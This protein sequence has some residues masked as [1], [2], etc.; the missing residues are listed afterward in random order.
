MYRQEAH[1]FAELDVHF[2]SYPALLDLAKSLA[3]H[4]EEAAGAEQGKAHYEA[5]HSDSMVLLDPD[6]PRRFLII[7]FWACLLAGKKPCLLTV[8]KTWDLSRRHAWTRQ[9]WE[10]L[11]CPPV[12]SEQP[13]SLMGVCPSSRILLFSSWFEG[14]RNIRGH[15]SQPQP[16]KADRASMASAQAIAFHAVSQEGSIYSYS[17]CSVWAHLQAAT[18]E[19]TSSSL[20]WMP[21]GLPT[22][23]L[24]H[25]AAVYSLRSEV[26]FSM[27]GVAQPA[28]L[29]E[30]IVRH[31]LHE[32]SAPVIFF[33]R[34]LEPLRLTLANSSISSTCMSCS[35]LQGLDCVR[36][37]TVLYGSDFDMLCRTRPGELEEFQMLILQLSENSPTSPPNS[38]AHFRVQLLAPWGTGVAH[39]GHFRPAG[40][41]DCSRVFKLSP[42][43]EG[44]VCDNTCDSKGSIRKLEVR[45]LATLPGLPDTSCAALRGGW[46]STGLGA[47]LELDADGDHQIHLAP[48]AG[49]VFR[50]LGG[51]EYMADELEAALELASEVTPASAVALS[52]RQERGK[53][54]TVTSATIEDQPQLLLCFTPARTS[55]SQEARLVKALSGHLAVTLGITPRLEPLP[56]GQIL[57]SFAGRPFK[58]VE[59]ETFADSA[60]PHAAGCQDLRFPTQSPEELLPSEWA[61]EEDFK[62]YRLN[63]N[64]EVNEEEEDAL[65]ERMEGVEH[66]Q[67]LLQDPQSP[68]PS[69]KESLALVLGNMN[70]GNEGNEGTAF[71]ARLAT[72]VCAR[73][74]VEGWVAHAVDLEEAVEAV[75]VV[76]HREGPN[77]GQDAPTL[78]VHLLQTD[79]W[80][81]EANDV[82]SLVQILQA[83]GVGPRSGPQEASALR[84]LHVLC[85]STGRC[86]RL[87]G[88]SS[89]PH[90]HLLTGVLL[91][92]AAE[93]PLRVCHVDVA[94]SIAETEH[95][96]QESSPSLKLAELLAPISKGLV[97]E[98]GFPAELLVDADG[99][100]LARRLRPITLEV[101][102]AA[103]A[104]LEPRT[105]LMAGGAGGVGALWAQFL[106]AET[107]ILLGRSHPA[108]K[109]RKTLDQLRHVASQVLYIPVDVSDRRLLWT[110]LQN[111]PVKDVDFA[112]SLCESFVSSPLRDL[113]S[114]SMD[115]PLRKL[116]GAENVVSVLA[117]LSQG[118]KAKKQLPVLFTST[119]VSVNGAAQLA[120]YA[121]GARALEAF[122]ARERC[123]HRN[124]C[125]VRC[126]ALSAWDGVGI[127]EKFPLLATAAPAA[128]LKVLSAQMGVL[129]LEAVFQRF[130]APRYGDLEMVQVIIQYCIFFNISQL[131]FQDVPGHVKV[132]WM[133]Y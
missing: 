19:G 96:L 49:E 91:S 3:K 6:M 27:D 43:I 20:S 92:A 4:I 113:D 37:W 25:C 84:S 23:L 121:A 8:S 38:Q 109:P 133:L 100:H 55:A 98:M 60:S 57:R 61:F 52:L 128:G 123:R 75:E 65:E 107:L 81:G 31:R 104:A 122:C 85:V 64:N 46:V 110:A 45:G 13:C 125:D 86:A 40:G 101:S 21:F 10:Q 93:L 1:S 117:S 99:N 53:G 59:R 97:T 30:V 114:T 58:V 7:A 2:L 118:R 11:Q 82:V 67:P 69:G 95:A 132:V 89:D 41:T 56:A 35:R 22:V 115:G 126:V 79:A 63:P 124:V 16:G 36:Q 51:V 78:L 54:E 15:P 80:P 130:T 88:A 90:K 94:P 127:T 70:E 83:W 112:C 131:R 34:A 47:S 129:A 26:H 120:Q 87:C 32:V 18:S 29:L 76:H 108:G 28:S 14:E 68:Q 17:S 5:G 33:R 9:M 105:V 66:N 71:S 103:H 42:G 12:L 44:R 102:Q 50:V 48:I 116:R 77:G 119:A 24:S 111:C 74:S 106:K 39:T 73:L 72:A 62:P